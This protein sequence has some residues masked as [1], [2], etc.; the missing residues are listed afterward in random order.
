MLR[1]DL[2]LLRMMLDIGFINW[3]EVFGLVMIKLLQRLLPAALLSRVYAFLRHTP[4]LGS[5]K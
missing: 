5:S 2:R 3:L 4:N 1:Q